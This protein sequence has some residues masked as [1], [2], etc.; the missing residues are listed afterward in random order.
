M[1][2]LLEYLVE[3]FSS[4]KKNYKKAITQLKVRLGKDK[5]LIEIYVRELLNLVLNQMQGK[6]M[7]YMT[8]ETADCY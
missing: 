1:V 4:S 2:L 7:F 6:Y 5:F 3:S 8:L